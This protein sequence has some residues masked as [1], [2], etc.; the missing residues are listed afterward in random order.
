MNAKAFCLKFCWNWGLATDDAMLVLAGIAFGLGGAIGLTRLVNTLLFGVSATDGATF[1]GVALLFLV[2]ST[3][4]VGIPGV[5][6]SLWVFMFGFGFVGPN[7][8]ALGMQR[9]PH[10]AGSAAAVLGSFQFGMAGDQPVVGDWNGD[11][12]TDLGVFRAAPDGITGE[13]I[14]D[15][16]ENHVMDSG[17]TTFTFGLA[18][19]LRHG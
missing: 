10:A 18:K 2:V 9:Y 13:F 17:D 15:T 8:A 1:A 14:L 3:R 7:A 5:I 12:K 4:I 16:N 19:K 11:G 6:P